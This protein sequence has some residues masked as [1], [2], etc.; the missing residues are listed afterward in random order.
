[1]YER[2]TDKTPPREINELSKHLQEN[3][4][5]LVPNK[6][7]FKLYIAETIARGNRPNKE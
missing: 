4:K 1:V 7:L 3:E 5:N 6:A 2:G